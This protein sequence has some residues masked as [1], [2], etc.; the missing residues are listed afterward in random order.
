MRTILIPGRR[1]RAAGLLTLLC[2]T[3]GCGGKHTPVP[4]S[5]TVTLDGQPLEGATVYFYMVG[6]EREGR[7][8]MGTTNKDGEFQLSTLGNNDGALPGRYKV[9][10][11][12]YVPTNPNLKIPDFP[13]TLEGRNDRQDFMYKNFEAKGIQPFTNS[14]PPKYGDSNSTP[15]EVEVS[16]KKTVKLELTKN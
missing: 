13:D 6:D 16:G 2:A 8:A 14:L 1:L 12:K 4:V 5:G 3:A 10:I 9:V 15:L 7:P 11:T